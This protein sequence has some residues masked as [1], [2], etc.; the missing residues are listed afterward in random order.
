M[1]KKYTFFRKLNY[2]IASGDFCYL[3]KIF[4]NSLDRG[5]DRQ[6]DNSL[7]PDQDR[8]NGPGSKPFDTLIV[9]LK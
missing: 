5:Q 1:T 9:F 7:D 2:F 4:A 8:Q 6:N 3:L